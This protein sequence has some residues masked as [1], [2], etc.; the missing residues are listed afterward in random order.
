MKLK[1]CYIVLGVLLGWMPL[2]AQS[3]L[4]PFLIAAA[5]NNPQLQ[6]RM[7][8]YLAALEKIP[9]V[10][11][12]PDPQLVMAYFLQPIETRMG[13]QR[14]RLAVSQL[15]PWFGTLNASESMAAE[16]AKSKLEI[17]EDTKSRLFHEIRASYYSLYLTRKALQITVES[18]SILE[19]FRRLALIKIENGKGKALD[20]IRLSMELGDLENQVALLKD[21]MAVQWSAFDNLINS[22]EAGRPEL[23]DELE[24]REL[25]MAKSVLQDRILTRNH[26]LLKLDL[27]SSALQARKELAELSGKPNINL[28]MEYFAIGKGANNMEGKDAFIFPVLGISL[29]IYREKY[30][31]RVQEVVYHEVAKKNEKADKVNMLE[32]LMESVLKDMQDA[33]RRR[34]LFQTQSELAAQALELL[35]VDFSAD[36]VPFEEILRMERKLLGYSLQLEKAR[37]DKASALSYIDYLV[38]N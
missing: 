34:V 32:N 1:I 11:S 23:P 14:L 24:N 7:N 19:S 5:Q 13:P 28:G 29:P 3:E 21:Q 15:F 20:D 35:Q 6:A 8:E 38:G 4:D 22:P 18:Q 36:R 2:K 26:Q 16:E 17:F 27:E 37:S 10:G 9:Q 12:L 25:E 31:A 33:E 30:K